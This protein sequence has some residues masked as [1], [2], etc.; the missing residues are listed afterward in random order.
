MQ[1]KKI[2]LVIFS[3]FACYPVIAGKEIKIPFDKVPIKVLSQ[4]QELLPSAK[5]KSAN[6][7]IEENEDIVYEIQGVLWDTRK[8]E[9]DVLENGKIKEFEIEFS[10]DLVPDVVIKTLKSK[11]PGFIPSYI[12]A[13]YTSAKKVEGYEFEGELNGEKIEVDISADGRKIAQVISDF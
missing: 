2:I 5:F 13:S 10:L 12:E 11:V 7:E 8:V 9:V 6:I 4:A 3:L 1:N